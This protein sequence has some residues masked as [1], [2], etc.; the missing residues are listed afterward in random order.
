[1]SKYRS[2]RLNEEIKKYVSTIIQS[3][4]KDPRI[5]TLASVTRVEVTSDLT[6]AKVYISTFGEEKSRKETI[7]ALKKSSGFIRS[8]LGKVLKVR[9]IPQ[10]LIESDKSLEYGMHIESLLKKIGE[11][12]KGED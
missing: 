11:D 8:E 10:I 2:G 12:S 7:D 6:Y 9:H 3:K 4:V 5:S 1:M